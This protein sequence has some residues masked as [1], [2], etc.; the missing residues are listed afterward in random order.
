MTR[1]VSG[2]LV[3]PLAALLLG[4]AGVAQAGDCR[5]SLRPLLLDGD[6][7]ATDI[8][9]VRERCVRAADAGDADALYQLAL[10]HLGLAGRWEPDQALP[11]IRRAADAGIPEAQYW[12]AWQFE[13]G[14]LLPDDQPAALR[15]Y[16]AAAASRHRLA[17][18]RLARAYERGELGLPVD[19]ARALQVRAEIRRCEEES[20]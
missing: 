1:H 9:R 14:P 5:D 4:G 18:E 10:I 12:L 20:R 2:W 13:E 7:A 11:L 19:R 17:L 8:A 15:W 6:P 3:P 16:E